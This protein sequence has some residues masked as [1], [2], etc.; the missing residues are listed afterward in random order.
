MYK[1]QVPV[2][3]SDMVRY[4]GR[5]RVVAELRRMG[6]ERVFL[7]TGL[8]FTVPEERKT[9]MENL[10]INAD[11]F[12]ARGFEVGVWNW[13]FA[14]RGEN[15]FT[16]M[17]TADGK[18]QINRLGHACP[19]DPDFR[20]MAA[21]YV[22]DF[23]RAGVEM[24]MYDDDFRYLRMRAFACTCKRHM[25]L[26]CEEIGEE[27]TP[28]ELM[29]KAL[30]GGKNRYRD[31][32]MRVNGRVLSDF[33]RDMR[34]ALDEVNPS[35]RMGLCAVMSLWDKDGVDAATVTRILAGNTKPFM[36]LIG[37]PYWAVKVEH[38]NSRLQNVIE[39]H[40]M[41]RCFAGEGIEIF[42]EGDSFPRPR[43]AC[44]A[45]YVELFDMAMRCDGGF[46]GILKYSLD[47]YAT[48]DY[49]KGYVDRQLRNKK[50]Y[51]FIDKHF[52]EKSSVG[53]KIYEKMNKLSDTVIPDTMKDKSEVFEG[54]YPAASRMMADSS[55][56]TVF[57]GEGVCTAIFGENA[58]D[59]P[60]GALTGGIILDCAAAR[61]LT[62]AGV[63]V[64]LRE[65]LGEESYRFE[66]FPDYEEQPASTGLRAYKIKVDES[67][68]IKS[69]FVESNPYLFIRKNE[70]PAAYLY[71]N[72][73]GVRFLVF[74]F[75]AYYNGEAMNRSYARSRQISDAVVWLS[76]RKLPAYCYG[77]PDLYVMAK[78]SETEMAVGLLNCFADEAIE[79]VIELDEEYSAAEFVGCSGR[80]EGDKVILS[81]IPPFSFAA[82]ALKKQ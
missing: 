35:V 58:R 46:D 64:G 47:L 75:D 33:A 72:A 9:V 4:G 11:Y 39:L 20:K 15:N 79:P 71:E 37:A 40:R 44:P 25:K 2:V 82:V 14:C 32:W 80:L 62:E 50:K 23:A 19:L 60:K 24:I 70:T 31:A 34:R 51:D 1:I 77:N 66:Y 67:A 81:D 78:K 65:V 53:I 7:A 16:K 3:D 5:E 30:T 56:P 29:D 42:A 49:E 18:N 45:S 36:R 8:Y 22:R 12:K 76:G 48:V 27:I 26:F 73:D 41:E 61:I 13:S 6:A 55:I 74:S 43:H 69:Y 28:R 10:K 38:G 21:D 52:R 54:F 17:V 57:S 63:D 68:V 59:L